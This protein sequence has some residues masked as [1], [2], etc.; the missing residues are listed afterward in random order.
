MSLA[1]AR[2]HEAHGPARHLFALM[3]ARADEG[4]V[5]WVAPRWQAGRLHGPGLAGL[6]VDPGRFVFIHADHPTDLLWTLE[7]AL[8]AGAVP[9]V[10]GELPSPPGLT[11]MRRL[12]LAA[13]AGAER[14]AP[15]LG[16][17]LTPEGGAAGAESRWH[18]E[19]AHRPDARGWTLT[20]ERART[21]P[22][23][24][25]KVVPEGTGLALMPLPPSAPERA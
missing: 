8:R 2:V 18:M 5:F 11:P 25:W 1:R 3:A 22:P 10:V 23:A 6:G 4:P 14:G 7:E 13:E 15:P 16:L 24:S 19:P 20:R 17:V 9:L 12:Q 21:E